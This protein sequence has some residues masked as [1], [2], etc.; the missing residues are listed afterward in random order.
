MVDSLPHFD[1]GI[2]RIDDRFYFL[3]RFEGALDSEIDTS[4]IFRFKWEIISIA[5]WNW[6]FE[7]VLFLEDQSDFIFIL[8]PKTFRAE[9]L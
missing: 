8:P 4:H 7:G 2:S 1:M 5:R 3:D 6:L 9:A